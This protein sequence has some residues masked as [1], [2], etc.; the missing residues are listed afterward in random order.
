LRKLETLMSEEGVRVSVTVAA[1]R[2]S[3]ME[4]AVRPSESRLA[5]TSKKLN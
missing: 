2:G 3:S 5:S 1:R 4:L